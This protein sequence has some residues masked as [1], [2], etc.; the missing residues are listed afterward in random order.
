MV[1]FKLFDSSPAYSRLD[2]PYTQR[3]QLWPLPKPNRVFLV[4]IIIFTSVIIFKDT[5]QKAAVHSKDFLNHL[6]ESPVMN[7]TLGVR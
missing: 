6:S 5:L 4:L 1:S 3:R 7:A 2:Y